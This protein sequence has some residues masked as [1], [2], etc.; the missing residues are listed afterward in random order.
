M[1]LFKTYTLSYDLYK[2]YFLLSIQYIQIWQAV[3]KRFHR[4][5]MVPICEGTFDV[6]VEVLF[7]AES[8]QKLVNLRCM[9]YT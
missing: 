3:L 6:L 1:Q 8:L 7:R 9:H 2:T 5:L 4:P